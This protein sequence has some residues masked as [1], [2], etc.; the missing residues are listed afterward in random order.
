MY[1]S[2]VQE[3]RS[4][5]LPPYQVE[6]YLVQVDAELTGMREGV[7]GVTSGFGTGFNETLNSVVKLSPLQ[8]L[9]WPRG[10]VEV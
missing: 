2:F 6:K 9:L 3:S 7:A 10:W 5:Q 4:I 1:D 8:A